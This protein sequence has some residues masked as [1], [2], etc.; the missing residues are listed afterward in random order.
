MDLSGVRNVFRFSWPTNVASCGS[1]EGNEGGE[2]GGG[3][4]GVCRCVLVRFVYIWSQ[5]GRKRAVISESESRVPVSFWTTSRNS[6]DEVV[7]EMLR[8]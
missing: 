6:V 1:R 4:C 8:W 2:G 5:C 3:E 7:M